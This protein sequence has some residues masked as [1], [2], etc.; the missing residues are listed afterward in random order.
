VVSGTAHAEEI[1]GAGFNFANLEGNTKLYNPAKL[2]HGFNT[3]AGEEIF[4]IANPGLGLWA[5]KD[6]FQ[7]KQ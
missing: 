3:V 4:F 5:S 7:T 1:E 2:K 6:K